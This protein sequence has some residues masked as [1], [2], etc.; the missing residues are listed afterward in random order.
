M[1]CTGRQLVQPHIS[2]RHHV[3]VG[4]VGVGPAA[5]D[6]RAVHLD[7]GDRGDQ[8]PWRQW[9]QHSAVFHH[10]RHRTAGLCLPAHFSGSMVQTCR[11]S[12]SRYVYVVVLSAL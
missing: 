6:D 10:V 11:M 5:P 3:H 12:F 8:R 7:G 4:R 1:P 2:R 9:T